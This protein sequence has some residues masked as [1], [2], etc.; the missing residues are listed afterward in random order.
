MQQVFIEYIGLILIILALVMLSQR[1]KVSYPIVVVLG[2]LA[3][4]FTR[5]FSHITI[6]PELIFF[7]FS[8]AAAV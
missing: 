5:P 4:S 1:L 8:S 7:I 3:L 2:G 6:D